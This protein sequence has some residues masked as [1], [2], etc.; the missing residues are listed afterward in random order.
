M[1]VNKAYQMEIVEGTYEGYASD[2]DS[3]TGQTLTLA[4]DIEAGGTED[5]EAGGITTADFD[6]NRVLIRELPTLSSIFGAENSA[7]LLAGTFATAD[8]I[9]LFSSGDFSKYYYFSG[10]F[11]QPAGWYDEGGNSANDVSIHF[12][13]GL[14]IE[15]RDAAV[16]T[17][18]IS[19]SVKL[20]PTNVPIYQGFNLISNPSPVKGRLT[21]A[22]SGLKDGLLAGTAA[23]ADII[24]LPDGSGSFDKY[25]YFNGGFGQPAGWY[26][27]ES[28]ANADA[29][30]LPDAGSF[31]VDRRTGNSSVTISEDIPNN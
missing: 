21:L 16:K 2:I 30:I 1:D 28:G 15:T 10:G 22:N 17:I 13:D 26:E 14:I 19:G 5:I 7:G 18:S 8:L 4:E 9:Y 3:W 23:T 20:G 29:V 24:Y 6:G 12:G 27:S 11:G 31:F 25:Y